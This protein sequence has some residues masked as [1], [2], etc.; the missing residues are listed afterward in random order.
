M[1]LER[2]ATALD[3][4]ND[5][6]VL[7]ILWGRL[8]TILDEV[9]AA[10]VRT[11]FSTVL[12]E[13]RDFA[14]IL[15]DEKARALA[16]GTFSTTAFVVT[17]PE[18]A[19]E[20]LRA[21]PPSSLRPGDV[22][23]TN[24]AWLG[25]GHLD[26]FSF[27]SPVFKNRRLVGYVGTVAHLTDV[28]GRL[29]YF[30]SRDALEE[31]IRIPPCRLFREGRPDRTI[32]EILGANVRAPSLV[33]GDIEAIAATHQ[34]G[35]SR[36]SQL[37][38]EYDLD[39]L[40]SVSEAILTRSAA[41]MES[42]IAQIPDGVYT[43]S[44]TCDGRGVPVTLQATVTIAGSRLSVDLAGPPQTT[45]AP[46]NVVWNL[47]FA[48]T[49][50]ALKCALLPET[51]NNEGL[52]WPISAWAAEGS[53]LNC[54]FPV[55][56]Q[57]RT[58]TCTHTHQ[59]IFLALGQVIPERVQAGSS[60]S[61]PV[62][63]RGRDQD[64]DRFAIH[65]FCHGGKGATPAADGLGAT[66]FPYNS[67]H[68]SIEIYENTAAIL[69]HKK[70][71]RRD[72]GGPGRRRGG[73]GQEIVISTR[74]SEPVF[75]RPK[76]DKIRFP[77]VGM[78]GGL[79]GAR[80]VFSVN[81]DSPELPLSYDLMPG[82]VVTLELPGGGGFG[83]PLEREPSEVLSDVLDGLVSR[84]A[85]RESYGVVI[86]ESGHLDEEETRRRRSLPPAN[87]PASVQHP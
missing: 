32:F 52:Y 14:C 80:G 67:S 26:D 15:L 74:S 48:D 2:R 63:F 6:V 18:A 21:F 61:W 1:T 13:G 62:E 36:L 58:C 7:E 40:V 71:Y 86:D 22:L 16:Q 57:A 4:A 28:G 87:S 46:I 70:E 35:A 59:T 51:R 31:G 39:D 43:G 20:L 44:V 53:I 69:V 45:R 9:D 50:F 79:P 3:P 42:A 64:G 30:D 24:D 76:P 5:P 25:A 77:A 12:A 84:E 60:A 54:T 27:L 68:G 38:D 34:L 72:S 55:A 49:V 47:T 81:D 73:V 23:A 10:T 41:S 17:L 75:A 29:D 33:L 66:A 8:I 11:A 82:D 78:A 37:L 83:S 19:K 85:A 65:F 56:V